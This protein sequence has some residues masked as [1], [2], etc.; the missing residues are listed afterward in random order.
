M[1]CIG[2]MKTDG[3]YAS[4]LCLCDVCQWNIYNHIREHSTPGHLQ[5]NYDLLDWF[6]KTIAGDACSCPGKDVMSYLAN[7]SW[8]FI[9]FQGAICFS[10]HDGGRY[11][12]WAKTLSNLGASL[13]IRSTKD[14]YS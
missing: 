6:K 5:S 12:D 9:R 11:M 2:C 10:F 7:N 3:N 13:D 14:G 8:A 4:Q 1:L